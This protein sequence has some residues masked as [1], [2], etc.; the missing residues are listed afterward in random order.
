LSGPAG[1]VAAVPVALVA[2]AL[3]AALVLSS[4]GGGTDTAATTATT[5][6]CSE[7]PPQRLVPQVVREL[8]HATDAFTE[9]LVMSDGVL[10]ESNGLDGRSSVRAIDPTT[11]TVRTDV[12]VDP[13]V[14]AEGLAVG[15]GGQLV[16]LTWKSGVAFRRDPQTLEPVGR[17]TYAGEGWGL[18]TLD[19]GTLVQSDGTD[20]LVERD[21]GDFHEVDRWAV[22]RTGGPTDQ[23]NELDWDGDHLWANRWQTDEIVRIDRRCRR[24]DAVVDATSLVESATAA[25]ARAGTPIDVLNGIAHVP[26]TDRHF[27]TG[28]YWPVLYE[29]RFVPA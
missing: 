27:V 28:K 20:Q 22:A 4:C 8:P 29:V 12:A 7:A 26:G 13:D 11:G 19:D 23:L 10:Y 25:A 24:V 6:D 17:F 2:G 15:A 3:A 5:A 16:Q 14:F 21:P 9:G 18:T 1:R